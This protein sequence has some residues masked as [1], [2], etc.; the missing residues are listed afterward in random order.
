MQK[1]NTRYTT[2]DA[3]ETG[4]NGAGAGGS[5]GNNINNNGPHPKPYLPHPPSLTLEMFFA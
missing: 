3:A 5:G 1:T 4:G 2:Y